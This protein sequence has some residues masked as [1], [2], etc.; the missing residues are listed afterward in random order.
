MKNE[1]QNAQFLPIRWYGDPILREKALPVA[2]FNEDIKILARDMVAT[3][4]HEDGCGIAGPQVGAGLRIFAMDIGSNHAFDYQ[5]DGKKIP[6]NMLF[7]LVVINPK[8]LEKSEKM[9]TL[10]ESCMSLPGLSSPVTRPE[11][12][13]IEFQDVDGHVHALSADGLLAT[14]IQHEYD[15]LEG[16]LITDYAPP[17]LKNQLKPKLARIKR[18]NKVRMKSIFKSHSV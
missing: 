2:D 10:T 7:P 17:H 5:Y 16:R 4:Y 3:M 6:R 8:F 13:S 11:F 1:F 9:N 15:H 18:D 14:C 12:V